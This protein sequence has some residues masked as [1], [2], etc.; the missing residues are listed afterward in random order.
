[1]IVD[2]CGVKEGYPS[3]MFLL[4]EE[5]KKYYLCFPKFKEYY[6]NLKRYYFASKVETMN[7]LTDWTVLA[8]RINIKLDSIIREFQNDYIYLNKLDFSDVT[9]PKYI[10]TTYQNKDYLIFELNKHIYNLTKKYEFIK[11]KPKLCE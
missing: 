8:W 2:V 11:I 9:F 7:D 10:G 4:T 1:M 5:N 6:E 3:L